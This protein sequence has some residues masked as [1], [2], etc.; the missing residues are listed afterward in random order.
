MGWLRLIAPRAIA[1]SSL[2]VL[3]AGLGIDPDRVVDLSHRLLAGFP[4]FLEATPP[5]PHLVTAVGITVDSVAP[6][7]SFTAP[8]HD[9]LEQVWTRFRAFFQRVAPEALVLLC[10][11]AFAEDVA[12]VEARLGRALP[13]DFRAWLAK[14]DGQTIDNG[15]FPWT[16]TTLVESMTT[17][18][19][20]DAKI[21]E[22]DA[23]G[24]SVPRLQGVRQRWW[25][26][27]WFPFASNGAG[28]HL[29]IDLDPAPGGIPGQ[30]V[31]FRSN[32]ERRTHVATSFVDWIDSTTT[33]LENESLLVTEE[34]DGRFSFVLERT[35]LT[36]SLVELRVRGEAPDDREAR[37]ERYYEAQPDALACNLVNWLR[38]TNKLQGRADAWP[39]VYVAVGGVLAGGA[40]SILR[41]LQTSAGI[42]LTDTTADE[43]EAAMT[44]L[45]RGERPRL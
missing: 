17:K 29:C 12:C 23:S 5:Q 34:S 36:G 41:A 9:A 1:P 45:R 6:P 43:I 40:P 32:H 26:D 35:S 42:T 30:V 44:L 33:Q 28:D 14:H 13:D 7:A 4:A 19:V 10:G 38:A 16:V 8:H 25:H 24:R 31:E 21:G 11:P 22:F 39:S 18:H 20:L 2:K 37:I 3:E 27:G 15:P